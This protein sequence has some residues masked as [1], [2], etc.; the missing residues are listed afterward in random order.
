MTASEFMAIAPMFA[1][2][3]V[4]RPSLHEP[5]RCG[6][7]LFATDG[8]I[9]LAY[10]ARFTE[11][12]KITETTDEKRR[13]LGKSIMGM[14]ESNDAK[15]ASGKYQGFGLCSMMEA[16][17]AA[18]ANVEPAMMWLRANEP[19]E[20]DPDADGSP[21]SVRHVHV[22]FTA[23]IM[24]NPARSLIAGYYA[25]LIAGLVKYHGPVEAYADE[26]DP[27]AMLYFRGPDWNCV[28][29]PR[30]VGIKGANREWSYYFGGC[31]IADA[32]TGTLVWGRDNE[33]LPDLDALRAGVVKSNR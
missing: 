13:S 31:S 15:I 6:D 2:E 16:V 11:L 24:A 9:A 18:F 21:D 22:S 28:L 17:I 27:H 1:S 20:D 7:R 29:M 23:V 8:R 4:T 30:K 14:I 3:D 5:F 33:N 32:W 19:D 10:R 25:S 12:C 26:N